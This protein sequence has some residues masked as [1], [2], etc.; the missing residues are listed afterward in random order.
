MN[1]NHE[2]LVDFRLAILLLQEAIFQRSL[3]LSVIVRKAGMCGETEL[4]IVPD[5]EAICPQFRKIL[6]RLRTCR[7]FHP[8]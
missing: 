3:H 5:Q 7:T 6:E 2:G 8:P 1:V 4:R